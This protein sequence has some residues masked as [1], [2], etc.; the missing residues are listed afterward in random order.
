MKYGSMKS[1][2]VICLTSLPGTGKTTI[3]RIIE[4][5]F[6]KKGLQEAI[7]RDE[8]RKNV[9]PELGFSKQ[10]CLHA[11][12]MPTSYVIHLFF[13]NNNTFGFLITFHISSI[14]CCVPSIET[15]GHTG[16]FSST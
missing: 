10:E 7:D 3:A 15:Q 14:I 8:V 13:L 2:Y 16:G 6:H 1:A 5:E 9:S 4:D 12:R 11:K